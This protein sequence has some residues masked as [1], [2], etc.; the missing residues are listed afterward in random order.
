VI[1]FFPEQNGVH[2]EDCDYC[3]TLMK[4]TCQSHS[5]HLLPWRLSRKNDPFI[6]LVEFWAE[7]PV[8]SSLFYLFF[9]MICQFFIG[10]CK[11]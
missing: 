2:L 1:F 7:D 4:A 5:T 6:K 8:F 3:F 11:I 10:S 9:L